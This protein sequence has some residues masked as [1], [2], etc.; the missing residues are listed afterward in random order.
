MDLLFGN[1]DNSNDYS[2]FFLKTVFV[3]PSRFRPE[4]KLGDEK[5]LHDQTTILGRI[6]QINFD[7]KM[8]MIQERLAEIIDKEGEKG[9]KGKLNDL[10]AMSTLAFRKSEWFNRIYKKVKTQP[11]FINKWL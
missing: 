3:P 9:K 4:S 6:L 5:Y 10:K 11:E 2:M 8:I 1:Y 7:L